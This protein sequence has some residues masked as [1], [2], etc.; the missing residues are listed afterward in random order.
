[1]ETPPESFTGTLEPDERVLGSA[2]LAGQGGAVVVTQLGLWLPEGRRIGWHLLSKATWGGGLLV[3]T[4]AAEDGTL[5]AA[6]V[7]VDQQ[8]RRLALGEPGRV[9]E[10]VHQ[11]VTGAIR[12]RDRIDVPGGGAWLLRRAV[13]GRDGLVLQVR[14][15]AGTDRDILR[16][17]L[18][19]AAHPKDP[20]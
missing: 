15:D 16:A 18:A 12:T 19:S 13:P 9:P 1:M 5:G 6:T 10:L 14:P 7:L 2:L 4:E 20:A 17:A 11:R 3:L 8:P